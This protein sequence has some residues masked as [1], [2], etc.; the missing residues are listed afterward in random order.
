MMNGQVLAHRVLLRLTF[1]LPHQ[2]DVTLEF[3]V[4]TGFVGFLTLPASAVA[5]MNLP[6]LRRITAN[7]ADD[8][9]IRVS[10]YTATI[11]WN[12]QE[13]EVEVLA[14]GRQPLLGTLMLDGHEL[15]AQFADGGLVMIE[16]L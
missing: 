5:A 13:R 2:P 11:V 7:L 1:R 4:D 10:V 15:S 8:S 12:G 9:V 3:A 14:M 6:F 16:T